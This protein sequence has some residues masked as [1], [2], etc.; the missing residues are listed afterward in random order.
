MSGRSTHYRHG[1]PPASVGASEGGIVRVAPVVR[2]RLLIGGG[3]APA[4]LT[5]A[6][7][8][9]GGDTGAGGTNPQAGPIDV[10]VQARAG[11]SGQLEI[12]YWVKLVGLFNQRQGKIRA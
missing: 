6:A 3:L 7:C 12:D 1:P 4:A 5:L 2:R 9:A 10:R 11:G 8:G